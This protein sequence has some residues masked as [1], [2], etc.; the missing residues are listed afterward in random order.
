MLCLGMVAEISMHMSHGDLI[1]VEL[2][3]EM[4]HEES[5]GKEKNVHHRDILVKKFTTD[6]PTNPLSLYTDP[7]WNSPALEYQTPPPELS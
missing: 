5:N 2:D 1:S 3:T 7:Y 4:E 6:I